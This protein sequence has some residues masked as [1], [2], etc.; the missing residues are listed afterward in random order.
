MN[1]DASM[2]QFVVIGEMVRE[3]NEE[4]ERDFPDIAVNVPVF[5]ELKQSDP[6]HPPA[7]FG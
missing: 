1:F 2:I 3:I 4:L 5:L 6:R 7:S